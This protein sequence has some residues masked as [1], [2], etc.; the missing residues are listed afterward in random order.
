MAWK[1]FFRRAEWDDERRLE[2]DAHLALE[3]DEQIA[4][5]V[6]PPEARLAAQKKFGNVT[7]VREDIFRM[8]T[9]GALD[10]LWRDLRY[11][12]RL[13]RVNPGFASVAVLS[14]ALGIGANTAIFSLVNEFLLRSLP[15]KNPDELVL[16]RSVE[17]VG[18]RVS[19]AGENNGSIDAATG[20]NSSTSFSLSTFE[21]FRAQHS[22]LSDVFA[23]APFS[24]VHVLVDGQPE[25]A[26]SAQ[27][28]SGNYHAGL[29][30]PAILGRTL[31]PEDD[32]PSAAPVAVISYRYW[33]NRFGHDAAVLGKT[34]YLNRVPAAIVGVT[35]P[36]FDGAMQAGESPSITVPLAHYLRFQPDRAMR[37][38]PWYWWIR[39]MARL[40]PGATAEQA[41]ASLEPIFQATAR[42]GWIA[43]R[44]RD[45][46]PRAIPADPILRADPGAQGENETRRR[47]TKSL[48]ILMGLVSLVLVAACANVANLV[49]ARGAARRREIALRLALGASRARVVTQLLA[50]SLLLA[51]AGAAIGTML[52]WWSRGLLVAL[53][54]FG[55]T[56]GNTA[57]VLDLPLDTRVLGFTIACA[58]TTAVLFGLAPA[59]RATRVDLNAEFQGGTRSLGS[60]GRSRLS[61]AL[62]VV[63]I[64]LSLVL[65]VSTGLFVRTLGHL[66][67]V[68]AG[69]N[70]RNLVLFTIDATSAGYARDQFASLHARLQ[71]RLEKIPG[72]R[73]ATFSRVAVLSRVRQ[74]N[75][76]SVQ[77]LPSP[78]DAAAGVNMNGL[79]ANFFAAMELPLVVGRGFSERDDATAP[80]VA[81]VNQALVKKYFG[82][83]NPIGRRIVYTLGP[84]ASYSAEIVG[85][86]GDAKYTD[87]RSAVPP[88]LY[89]PALQQLGGVASFALRLGS[90][91]PTTIF[92]A[93]RAAV[94]EID[95]TLPALDLRTQDEQLDRLH[96]QELLFARL[97]GFFGLLALAL[98]CVGLYGLMSYAVLRRTAE[99]GLR[100]ALGAR[101][102]QVV[103][104]MLRESVALVC[105]GIAAGV[106]AAYGLSRLVTAMLFGLSPTDPLTYAAVAAMLMAVA[107]AASGVPAFR[108]SRLEPT[109]ALR[110]K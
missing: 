4:R 86:A 66:Q 60:S 41:G 105:V 62:M 39:I 50:E 52:A 42:E 30:V 106:A 51:F 96:G 17:G 76:I 49:L 72:V 100:L 59:L 102:S 22:A 54:P 11:A 71:A 73:A 2:I 92:P 24:Q 20:R 56:F 43:G 88:T 87:L 5:G 25:L 37:A 34:I 67:N 89:L 69:F 94:R 18:G 70:R 103:G 28:A 81:V 99:I 57:V 36:G 27:L 48:Y 95:P 19:R 21:R 12:A 46:T 61:Q 90:P 104:M 53:R 78:P 97:S 7:L 82:R 1:R 3:I 63:Q 58:V 68:D 45:T 47:Y 108:A 98:A 10:T 31:T 74:S 14:L 9:I 8:N 6:S 33:E 101:P 40:A 55:T 15:V 110:E 85:V 23:F 83:E 29:G 80:T 38:E 26:V 84:A 35:P 32:R 65:L 13:L 93:I 75:T 91:D 77:G 79:A 44:S 109:E 107:T 16:F 64:A